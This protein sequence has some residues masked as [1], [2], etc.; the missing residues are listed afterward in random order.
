MQYPLVEL[1]TG[2]LLT[3][4]FYM[5]FFSVHAASFVGMYMFNPTDVFQALTIHPWLQIVF[6]IID[7]KIAS[8]LIA[9]GVYDIKHKIIP[10]GLVYAAAAFAFVKMLIALLVFG[11]SGTV[12]FVFSLG[13]GLLTALPFALLWL[14]SG[15]RWMGLGD[16]KLALVIGWA[17]GLS[18]GFTAIVYSF[19]IGCIAVLGI[20]LVR[21]LVHAFSDDHNALHIRLF[22]AK[23]MARLTEYIP[24]LKLKSE[25]PFGPYMII[26]LYAV[27]FTGKTL[28]GL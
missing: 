9:I 13:S 22:T 10:D 18:S 23:T 20:M 16:A 26:G 27:Y 6:L 2:I 28:F 8:I 7:L 1:C 14:V 25:L 17:L 15:G 24:A 4:I 5:Y 12:D 11:S 3:S 21:E 19:W